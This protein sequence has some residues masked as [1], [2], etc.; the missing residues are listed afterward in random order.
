[1]AS[2]EPHF[3]EIYQQLRREYLAEADE[4]LAELGADAERFAAGDPGALASLKTRFHRLAGSAG[5]YGFAEI[6]KVARG[7]E[8]WIASGPE[9]DAGNGARLTETIQQLGAEFKRASEEMLP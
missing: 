6:G 3:D 2:E 9:S 4:R 1:M 8:I 5:S 7:A